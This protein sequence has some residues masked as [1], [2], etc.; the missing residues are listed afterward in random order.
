MYEVHISSP[1]CLVVVLLVVSFAVQKLFW[2]HFIYFCFCFLYLRNFIWKDLAETSV[3]ERTACVFLWLRV[4][5]LSV[6]HFKFVFLHG[7]RLWC[8]FFLLRMPVFSTL[9]IEETVLSLLSV[10]CFFVVDCSH[11]PGFVSGLS[12]LFHW[13]VCLPFCHYH[14]VLI[15]VVLQCSSK[16]GSVTPFPF[17]ILPQDYFGSSGFLWFSY[18]F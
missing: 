2:R 15:I 14:T 9:F 17:I 1:G 8:G 13:Y 6:I 5:H 18:T 7:V 10:L 16:S 4:L 3:R 12:V 11:V